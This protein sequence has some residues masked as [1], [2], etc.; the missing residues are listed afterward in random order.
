MRFMVMLKANSEQSPVDGRSTN[1]GAERA[2]ARDVLLSS[3]Q[4]ARKPAAMM[5]LCF[6]GRSD[7]EVRDA[8]PPGWPQFEPEAPVRP[9][10]RP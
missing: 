1:L 8:P 5:G 9:A 7:P 4:G 6:W 3:G 2:P 10:R